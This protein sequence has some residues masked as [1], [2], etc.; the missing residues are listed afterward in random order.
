MI[1]AKAG[2]ASRRCAPTTRN[3]LV[4]AAESLVSSVAPC[5][6]GS[7]SLDRAD[8][9]DATTPAS[10]CRIAGVA[11][12]ADVS[13]LL[14]SWHGPPIRPLGRGWRAPTRSLSETRLAPGAAGGGPVEA[15]SGCTLMPSSRA[16]SYVVMVL[17]VVEENTSALVFLQ[18]V[19]FLSI[20]T[21]P[22]A[23][24]LRPLGHERTVTST[25]R[26]PTTLLTSTAQ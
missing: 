5:H 18:F 21:L 4:L 14:R 26:T 19:V 25:R 22:V 10:R 2:L 9:R 8:G 16:T 6:R 3:E 15:G 23:A 17:M 24:P 11:L 12:T 20:S 13:L 1:R 7:P